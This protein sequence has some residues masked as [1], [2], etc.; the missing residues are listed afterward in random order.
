MS[1]GKYC[2]F[3]LV[4]AAC[5]VGAYAS[6]FSL[7]RS[8]LLHH[9]GFIFLGAA[10]PWFWLAVQLDLLRGYWAHLIAVWLG[11]SLNLSL[12]FV[13][14]SWGRQRWSSRAA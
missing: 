1:L 5:L 4:G 13:L 9:L 14:L 7:W 2:L 3:G 8:E 10:M 12:V 11:L 6:A